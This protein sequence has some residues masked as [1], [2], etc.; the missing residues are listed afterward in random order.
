VDA[1]WRQLADEIVARPDPWLCPG[2]YIAVVEHDPF[3]DLG[4]ESVR[5]SRTSAVV[6]GTLGGD[7][8]QGV[9]DAS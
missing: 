9:E 4:L 1:D 3:L 7:L 5:Y 6:I 2:T 8:P